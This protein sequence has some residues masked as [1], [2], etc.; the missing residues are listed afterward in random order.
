M[1][2]YSASVRFAYSYAYDTLKGRFWDKR[3]DYRPTRFA[4]G[5]VLV[6][7][8]TRRPAVVGRSNQDILDALTL[9]RGLRLQLDENEGYLISEARRRGINFADI[10]GA[11]GLRSPQA[12][13]HRALRRMREATHEENAYLGAAAERPLWG[14]R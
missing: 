7:L 10:A 3:T 2:K 1:P 5:A 6:D 14:G 4:I 8:L 12:A 9:V 13:E 11:L